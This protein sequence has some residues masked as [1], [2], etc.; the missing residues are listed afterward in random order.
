M[1]KRVT[2]KVHHNEIVKVFKKEQ[3]ATVVAIAQLEV[4]SRPPKRA[5]KAVVKDQQIAE[6]KQRFDSS[7]ISLEDYVRDIFAHTTI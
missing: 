7:S 2:Q 6:L 5:K 3:A 4:G 1:L